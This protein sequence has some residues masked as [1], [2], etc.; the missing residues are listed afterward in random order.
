MRTGYLAYLKVQR[1]L[2]GKK[3]YQSLNYVLKMNWSVSHVQSERESHEQVNEI[4]STYEK[5]G[6]LQALCCYTEEGGGREYVR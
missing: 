1:K 6:E 3:K 5:G 2:S 4:Q